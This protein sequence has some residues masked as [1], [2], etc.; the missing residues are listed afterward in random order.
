MKVFEKVLV[1]AE[2]FE[3]TS[4]KYHSGMDVKIGDFMINAYVNVKN[5]TYLTIINEEEINNK[6]EFVGYSESDNI[7]I[8]NEINKSYFYSINLDFYND[9]IEF[10]NEMKNALDLQQQGYVNLLNKENIPYIINDKF[11]AP[12]V[13][14]S[15]L[16]NKKHI[17]HYRHPELTKILSKHNVLHNKNF[18]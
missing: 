14:L 8:F 13:E 9:L 7:P 3:K 4:K 1:T 12:V 18:I 2:E 15:L 16:E 17:L 5:V 6:Y 10:T 11:N